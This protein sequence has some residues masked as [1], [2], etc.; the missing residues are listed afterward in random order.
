M[1]KPNKKNQSPPKPIVKRQLSRK[2]S[3]FQI[4]DS[5]SS[6]PTDSTEERKYSENGNIIPGHWGMVQIEN[7]DSNVSIGGETVAENYC[8]YWCPA[9]GK[10][11]QVRMPGYAVEKQKGTSKAAF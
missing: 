7:K 3:T 11:F 1:G 2:S 8:G 9:K 4:T 5:K 10:S 6:V